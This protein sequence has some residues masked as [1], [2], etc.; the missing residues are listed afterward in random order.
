MKVTPQDGPW[1]AVESTS[2]ADHGHGC[3]RRSGTGHGSAVR[4]RTGLTPGLRTLFVEWTFPKLREPNWSSVTSA[5]PDRSPSSMNLTPFERL[6]FVAVSFAAVVLAGC[7]RNPETSPG[8]NGRDTNSVPGAIPSAETRESPSSGVPPERVDKRVPA[9]RIVQLAR[10]QASIKGLAG[11]EIE[12]QTYETHSGRWWIGI[13][14]KAEDPSAFATVRIS[15]DGEAM[16]Y[17]PPGHAISEVEAVEL[18]KKADK[19]RS[20]ARELEILY[21]RK[22]GDIW[23]VGIRHNPRVYGG[24]SESEVSLGPTGRLIGVKETSKGAMM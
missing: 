16:E 2:D 22:V 14:A 15:E 3:G 9:D 11:V 13:R 6:G 4:N 5:I 17:L 8:S 12:F 24:G 19:A 20:R 1:I 23:R 21:A 10:E 7:G 18:A